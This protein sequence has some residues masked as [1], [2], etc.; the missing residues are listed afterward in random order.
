MRWIMR[1]IMAI[2]AIVAVAI[3]ALFIVPTERIAD[4][5]SE[6]FSAQTGRSLSISG[7]IRPS[8]FPSLGIRA[9]GVE[10]GNPDWVDL[11][12]MIRAERL[13]VG[14]EFMA[15]LTGDIRVD[16]FELV[17]PEIVLV[18]GADGAVSW[19]FSGDGGEASGPVEPAGNPSSSAPAQSAA[20]N[21][22]GALEGFS[23]DRAE[24]SSGSVIYRDEIGGTDVALSDLN[25]VVQLPGGAGVSQLEG[26]VVLNGSEV[27][28]EASIDGLGEML[29]G[30]L[31]PV[32]A[33]FGWSGGEAGFDGR[34]G[35]TPMGI[36]GDVTFEA[37]DLGPLMA[38][39]GQAPPDLPAGLGRERLA[40]EG[41]LT[42]ASEGSIHLR[43]AV[44]SLDENRLSGAIDVIPGEARPTIRARLVGARLDLSGLTD[45]GGDS[46][47]GQSGSTGWSTDPI[48]V[49]GLF[50]ADVEAALT[51]DALDLG[52]ANLDGVDIRADLENGRAVVDLRQISA[53]GGRIS[54]QYI[55]NGRGGLSMRADVDVADVQLA[56]LLS[57]FAGYDRLEGTG[58]GSINLLLI[59]NDMASLMRSID[60]EGRIAFGQGAILGLDIWGMIRNFDTSYQGEGSRTVYDQIA[61]SFTAEGGVF[62]NDD[63][64]MAA[65]IGQITGAGTVDVGR[66]VLDYTVIPQVLDGDNSAGIRVPLRISGAWSDPNFSLDLEALAEAELSEQID[67]LEEQATEAVSDALGI[68]VEEGQTLEEAAVES[69]EERLAREAEEQLLRLFGGGN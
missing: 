18:Q 3:G 20:S 51:L 15:L 38:L 46:S 27:T 25:M 28:L 9:E 39:A 69:L 56:P 41:A 31:R 1:L 5:A 50:A 13:H 24:I 48:D 68:D 52:I 54:G 63:L 29:D 49:S 22:G 64:V 34:V 66:Q 62:T 58:N 21:E 37:S 67:A 43:D 35:L 45:G 30:A 33:G 19:D 7:D 44:F 4:L 59:G 36:D 8:I 60:G 26:S 23:L 12:P 32:T 65:S 6:R 47:G 16:R 57:E 61:A 55:L 53:Y 2:F 10:L 40:V 14:V 42:L 17:S 11:G